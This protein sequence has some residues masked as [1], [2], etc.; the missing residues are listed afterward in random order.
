M[1]FALRA[2]DSMKCPATLRAF[3]A[4]PLVPFRLL[5]ALTFQ[6]LLLGGSSAAESLYDRSDA[7]HL[8]ASQ[9]D[10]FGPHSGTFRYDS[11][12]IRAARIAQSRAHPQTTWHCW[13]YVKDALV[14]ADVITSRPETAWAKQAG[15]ELC[16]R[17]G[18]R[19]LALTDPWKA[20]LGAVIVYGGPDAGHVEMRTQSGFVSDFE[21]PTPYPRPLVGIY[22][23]QS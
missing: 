12:M 11:R 1:E 16:R 17:F 6:T 4:P 13:R 19:R 18:F 5:F 2:I 9:Q 22:V 14:A 20:P 21:S 10:D 23:K 8:S 15:E 7:R 3:S